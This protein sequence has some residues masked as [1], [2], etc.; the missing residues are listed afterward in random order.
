MGMFD[1]I[2]VEPRVI[3]EY[4]IEC[5]HCKE[6]PLDAVFQTKDMDCLMEHYYLKIGDRLDTAKLYYLDRPTDKSNPDL[7][8]KYTD[9]EI[10]EHNENSNC[11][12]IL[13]QLKKGDGYWLK[14]AWWPSQRNHRDMGEL[15]HQ[16][17]EM[18][19]GCKRCH[20]DITVFCKFT[21]GHLEE[22]KIGTADA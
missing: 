5:P 13:S 8:Y 18:Y 6:T 11:M 16:W 9:K 7:W 3:G 19:A 15:P 17:I 1:E 10:E 4:K 12:S 2:H 21:D 20:G 22:V 14:K